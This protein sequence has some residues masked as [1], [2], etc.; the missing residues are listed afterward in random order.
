MRKVL[1]L[2]AVGLSHRLAGPS[3]LA[4]AALV[5]YGFASAAGMMAAVVSG[6]VGP[7]LAREIQTA[8]AEADGWRMVFH[9]NGLL[10]QAFAKVLVL[11]SCVAIALWS[12]AMVRSRVLARGIGI[13]GLVSGSVIVIALVAGQLPLD[14]H[15]FG[16]V[17]LAQAVWFIVVGSLLCRRSS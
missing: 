5:L 3:R 1:F 2:G 14:V 6:F 16:L 4:V 8:S 11:A 10:N 7:E 12:V 17:V 15:G 13:Y 9:Y